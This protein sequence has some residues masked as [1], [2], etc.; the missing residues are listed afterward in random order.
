M[1]FCQSVKSFSYL[2]IWTQE[3]AEY[4]SNFDPDTQHKFQYF[5]LTNILLYIKSMHITSLSIY[6]RE[7][8]LQQLIFI[9]QLCTNVREFL[10]SCTRIVLEFYATIL[11]F[12]YPQ[13]RTVLHRYEHIFESPSKFSSL[14]YWYVHIKYYLKYMYIVCILYIPQERIVSKV[15]SHILNL[16]YIPKKGLYYR[17]VHIF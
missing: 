10:N 1:N 13:E 16:K 11:K 15:W 4:G 6:N 7:T 3:V 8:Q 17:F 2:W 14:F 12:L 5:L 9:F